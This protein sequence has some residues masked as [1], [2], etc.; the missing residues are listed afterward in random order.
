MKKG[1]IFFLG[2]ITGVLLF[3][4]VAMLFMLPNS[5]ETGEDDNISLFATPGETMNLKSFEIMQVLPNGSA[6]AN[7]SEKAK[8]QYTYYGSP[9]VLFPAQEGT[10]YYDDQIIEVPAKKVVRPVGTYKYKSAVGDKTVPIVK[11]FDK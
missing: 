2:M 11:F 6:L 3:V 8:T 9:I 10:E 4:F 5:Q 7:S 1:L